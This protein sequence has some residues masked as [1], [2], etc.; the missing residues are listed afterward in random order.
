MKL[1]TVTFVISLTIASANNLLRDDTTAQPN[2]VPS[3]PDPVTPTC[4]SELC[5]ACSGAP[6]LYLPCNSDDREPYD[7]CR[8]TL[9]LVIDEKVHDPLLF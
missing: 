2:D 7:V 9:R 3:T 8:Y 4:T 6:C 5:P 1:G